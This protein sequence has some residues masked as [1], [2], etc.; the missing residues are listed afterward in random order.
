[1]KLMET[2]GG[3]KAFTGSSDSLL[4]FLS[5]NYAKTQLLLAQIYNPRYMFIVSAETNNVVPCIQ[6]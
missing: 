3:L 1:M 6:P 2:T 5:P 4:I